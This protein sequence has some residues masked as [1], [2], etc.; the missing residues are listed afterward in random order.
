[1]KDIILNILQELCPYEDITA[2]TELLEEGVLDSM[3]IMLLIERL[4]KEFS[5]SIPAEELEPE[6]FADLSAIAEMTERAAKR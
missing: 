1:M 3:G 5:V 2:D 4:E 6:D